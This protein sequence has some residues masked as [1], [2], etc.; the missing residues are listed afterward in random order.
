LFDNCNAHSAWLS[1]QKIKWCLPLLCR[2][3]FS[4]P[5]VCK[6]VGVDTDKDITSPMASWNPKFIH[7]DSFKRAN[8]NKTRKT[9]TTKNKYNSGKS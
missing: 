9:P 3:S 1:I 8:I 5:I 4:R 7:N 6:C 2:S